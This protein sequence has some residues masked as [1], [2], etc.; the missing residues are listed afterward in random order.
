MDRV[1]IKRDISK[2]VRN[3]QHSMYQNLTTKDLAN[4]QI[5]VRAHKD[6]ELKELQVSFLRLQ[7]S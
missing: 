7:I 3:I 4:P 1:N 2:I 5:V 6:A